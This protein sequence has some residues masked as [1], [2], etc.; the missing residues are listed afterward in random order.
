MFTRSQGVRQGGHD[1]PISLPPVPLENR[2]VCGC[3]ARHSRKIKI[4]D[5]YAAAEY[6]FSGARQ[7]DA[8][9]GY[10]TKSMLV[11]PMNNEKGELLGVLQL[12]N[13]LDS[14]GEPVPFDSARETLLTGIASLAAICIANMQ[15]TEQITALKE[16]LVSAFSRAI[17]ER[18]HYTANHTRTMA[19]IAER[20]LDWLEQ[21]RHPWAFPP[22]KRRAFRMA[23]LL[24]DAGKLTIPLEVMDKATRL[25]GH[26][27]DIEER[28]RV[29]GLLD[30]IAYLEKRTGED[31]YAARTAEREE[32]LA[33]IQSVNRAARLEAN[34]PGG[35]ILLSRA[36]AEQLGGRARVTS[37]GNSIPLKG[38]SA[39]FEVLRLDELL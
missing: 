26:L 9:T 1:D 23:V 16:S 39:D 21:T 4:A 35:T 11:I 20:F 31:E 19:A 33:F 3:C 34:A 28:L 14:G 37:L 36:A 27:S 22:E 7:Y 17:D 29:I 18:S 5:V 24:H 15:Y 30:R 6:D 2:Y 25:A 32:T 38:K 10:R 8:M 13:A 12:I